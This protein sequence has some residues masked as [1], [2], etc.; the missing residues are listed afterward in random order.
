MTIIYFNISSGETQLLRLVLENVS[1][2]RIVVNPKI[3]FCVKRYTC[4][5]PS[6]LNSLAAFQE[7]RRK[8]VNALRRRKGVRYKKTHNHPNRQPT[9]YENELND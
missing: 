7:Q 5:F 3:K 2:L 6:F 9:T 1:P 8:E 4:L